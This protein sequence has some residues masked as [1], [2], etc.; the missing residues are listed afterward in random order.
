MDCQKNTTHNIRHKKHT[1]KNKT[2]KTKQN[3][4]M[5]QRTVQDAKITL[6]TLSYKK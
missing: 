6:I 4:K 3:R 5:E 2:D 1:I